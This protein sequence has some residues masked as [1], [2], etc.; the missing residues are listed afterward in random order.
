MA[1]TPNDDDAPEEM[2]RGRPSKLTPERIQRA[3]DAIL[4][5][6]F[7]E[8]AARMCGVSPRTFFNWMREGRVFPNGLYGEFRRSIIAAEAVAESSLLG[9]VRE[10]AKSDARYACWI[11]ERKHPQRWG[12][13]RGELVEL[14]KKVREIERMLGIDSDHTDGDGGNPTPATTK[15]PYK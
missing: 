13:Y 1:T 12:R 5:G 11:L 15:P 3:T 8:V 7:R 4:Q 10:A 9:E 14:R 2:P 6:N